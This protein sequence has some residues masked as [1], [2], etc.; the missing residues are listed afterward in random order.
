[1]SDQEVAVT[2]KMG[3]LETFGNRYNV[4]AKLVRETLQRTAFPDAKNDSEFIAMLVV[5][6]EYHLNPFTRQIYA[7]SQNGHVVPVVSIDGWIAIINSQETLEAIEFD[8]A[9]KRF[10]L[11]SSKPC[12]EWIEC[13]IWRSDR[14]KP[15]TVREYFDECYKSTPPW[16]QSPKRMLRHRALIQAGRLAF[17]LS[18]REPDEVSRMQENNLEDVIIEE[19]APEPSTVAEKAKKAMGKG[20]KTKQTQEVPDEAPV[21]SDEVEEGVWEEEPEIDEVTGE[22]LTFDPTAG[23]EVESVESTRE[24]VDEMKASI[25]DGPKVNARQLGTISAC[26]TK[27]EWSDEL[28][29]RLLE[30]FGAKTVKDLP[31][32]RADEF[33]AVLRAG[34]QPTQERLL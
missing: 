28:F 7:F 33:M 17:G 21:P 16:N 34:G 14:D 1:M 5:A 8:Y 2:P 32:S 9:E 11:G 29:A 6:N 3:L 25:V 12:F 27:L 30:E 31:A 20:R 10:V 26:R 19:A 23:P 13:S 15:I 18:F 24:A 22:I 4:P